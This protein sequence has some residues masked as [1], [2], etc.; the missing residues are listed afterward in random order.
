M[1]TK[2]RRACKPIKHRDYNEFD[3]ACAIKEYLSDHGI[4]SDIDIDIDRHFPDTNS[5]KLSVHWKEDCDS[6]SFYVDHAENI[7]P[8]KLFDIWVT[9][10][11]AMHA[12]YL[13]WLKEMK[14]EE[15]IA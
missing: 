11:E 4:S 10:R 5:Y 9:E 8:E 13:E 15:A 12:G 1:N 2:R 14:E 3:L 6:Q 7:N